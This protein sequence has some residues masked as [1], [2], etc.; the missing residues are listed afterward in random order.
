MKIKSHYKLMKY[1][2]PLYFIVSL[3]IGLFFVYITAAPPNVIIVYPTPHNYDQYQ[4]EDNA[5][6][7]FTIKQSE[8]PCPENEKDMFVVPIQ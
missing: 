7:C 3:A 4:Y 1:I 8:I 5:N 2:A 6:N